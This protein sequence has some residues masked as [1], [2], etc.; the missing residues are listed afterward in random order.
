MPSDTYGQ[1]QLDYPKAT[2]D[3]T[4]RRSYV[5]APGDKESSVMGR[6]ASY[7]SM[8]G[9]LKRAHEGS[10]SSAPGKEDPIGERGEGYSGY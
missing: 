6:D 1:M 5:G 10:Q 8:Q 4:R 9:E 3:A 7:E 2:G